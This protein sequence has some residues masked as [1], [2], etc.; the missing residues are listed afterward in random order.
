[1]SKLLFVGLRVEQWELVDF[2]V[3]RLRGPSLE[4]TL[5]VVDAIAAFVADQLKD[6][7]EP[8]GPGSL[9]EIPAAE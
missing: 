8:A 5:P 1:M 7:E 9:P 4:E 3:R 6:A 2:A